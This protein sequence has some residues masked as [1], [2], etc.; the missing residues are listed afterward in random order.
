MGMQWLSRRLRRSP[1]CNPFSV[2]GVRAYSQEGEDL[3]LKRIFQDQPQG[4]YID[5]GAHHPITYSNT[6]LLYRRGWR[7]VNIDAMPGS[8]AVFRE[9]RPLDINIECGVSDEEGE[10]TYFC[11]L[12]PELNTFDPHTVEVFRKH[13][14]HPSETHRIQVRPLTSILAEVMPDSPPPLDLMTIDVEGFEIK[15]LNSHNW[16]RFRPKV[17]VV[18]RHVTTARAALSGDLATYFQSKGYELIAKTLNS[19]FYGDNEFV[20][21]LEE[22]L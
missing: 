12:H 7:G 9:I 13:D 1:K 10:L 20:Q 5:V 15:V 16:D 4:F 3:L 21:H 17:L 8:M 11:Y 19:L 22:Q 2:K 14:L 6:H 18:E